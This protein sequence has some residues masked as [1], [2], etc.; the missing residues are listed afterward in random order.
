MS[1]RI[2]GF[3]DTEAKLKGD[4]RPSARAAPS[5]PGQRERPGPGAGAEANAVS[6]APFHLLP[7]G[8]EHVPSLCARR[9]AASGYGA[10]SPLQTRSLGASW[11]VGGAR[12]S[13]ARGSWVPAR[14]PAS[15]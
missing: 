15:P 4:R 9:G 6:T 14:T 11:A 5:T 2:H 7:G 10:L 13:P 12:V 3:W 8:F 1:A